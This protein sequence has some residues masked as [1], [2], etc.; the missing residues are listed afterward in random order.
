MR[1]VLTVL[2][3]VLLL[4]PSPRISAQHLQK[5]KEQVRL[6][7]D[8]SSHGSDLLAMNFRE[9]SGGRRQGWL[10]GSNTAQYQPSIYSLAE[11]YLY[12]FV[13][14]CDEDCDD[15]D[16]ALYGPDNELL[17]EDDE[18]DDHPLIVYFVRRSGTYTLRATIPSCESPSAGCYYG[19]R[20]YF[21]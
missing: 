16:F 20:A 3:L 14:A 11:G 12:A 21:K 7:L 9:L 18:L 19:V 13:G 8:A 5:Y 6:L 10:R 2:A 4:A 17:I 15:L 1:Y